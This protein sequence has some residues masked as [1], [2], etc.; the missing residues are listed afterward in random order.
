[1]LLIDDLLLLPGRFLGMVFREIY[2]LVQEE[3]NDPVTVQKG[4]LHLQLLYEMDEISLE[5]YEEREAEL[6]ARLRELRKQDKA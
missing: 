5:E 2:N 6:I 4:L 1:M 3:V